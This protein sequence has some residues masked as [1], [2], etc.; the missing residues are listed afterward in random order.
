M[1]LCDSGRWPRRGLTGRVLIGPVVSLPQCAGPGNRDCHPSVQ[2]AEPT[3]RNPGLGSRLIGVRHSGFKLKH[4]PV[5]SPLG[6]RP[7]R[8]RWASPDVGG[9]VVT[10]VV[11]F[12]QGGGRFDRGGALDMKKPRFLAVFEVG[13]GGGTRTPT[14]FR[15]TDFE[16]IA[17]AI[18]PHRHPVALN[19]RLICG[20]RGAL[21]TKSSRPS[22]LRPRGRRP[23]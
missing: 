15:E 2:K 7:L 19:A 8:P 5:P 10:F 11:T 1:P 20:T 14:P 22:T 16:S 18:S 17:S 4:R 23:T 13:T 9:H 6:S 3:C 12:D 21:A